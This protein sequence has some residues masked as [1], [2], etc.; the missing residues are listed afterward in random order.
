MDTVPHRLARHETFGTRV[1]DPVASVV[2]VTYETPPSVL[3]R[4]L[5]ALDRQTRADFELLV[6]DNGTGHDPSGLLEETGLSGVWVGL[7]RNVGP[8]V[9]RDLAAEEARASLL[10]FLDDDAVPAEDFVETHVRA[11]R[12]GAV[13]VRGRVRP[14]TD[15]V[16]NRLAANYDLGD[17]G[18]PYLL[19]IEGN[20]SIDRSTY[21]AVGGFGDLPWGHEGLVLTTRLLE[22]VDRERIRYDPRPVVHHDYARGLVELLD[23]RLRHARAA[24]ALEGHEDALDLYEAYDLPAEAR[25]RARFEKLLLYAVG[26]GLDWLTMLALRATDAARAAADRSLSGRS[27]AV[28]MYHSVGERGRYG[29]V[30]VERFRA[31][32][33]WLVDHYEVVD[34]ATLVTEREAPGRARVALTFDDAYTNFHDHA[35]PIVREFGV[36]VTLFVPAGLLDGGHPALASRLSRSPD[37]DP[38]FNDPQGDGEPAPLMTSEQ[39]RAALATGLVRL[40]NHTLTHPDLATTAPERLEAEIRGAKRRLE[41]E[42]GVEVDRFCYPYGRYSP[43]ALAL[44]RETHALAV[45]AEDEPLGPAA[46]PHRLPRLHAHEPWREAVPTPAPEGDDSRPSGSYKSRGG[47]SPTEM[48]GESLE[49]PVPGDER[50]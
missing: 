11:H 31:D 17:E 33:A 8:N 5:R 39:V 36:P 44:V 23:V 43:A 14:L 1:N 45:T 26:K 4:T 49:S 47:D 34:L 25:T 20:T 9:A 22:R 40:G 7:D 50:R 35:L 12:E 29:D 37:G 21:R 46:D 38:R 24:R 10:V 27:D 32:L 30:S 3:R 28:L 15:S 48:R 42:F 13:A 16:Y 6:V 18:F 2:L 19:D 41:R